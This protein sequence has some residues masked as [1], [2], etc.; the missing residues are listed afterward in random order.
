[1]N[2]KA[3]DIEN[4]WADYSEHYDGRTWK[5]YRRILAEFVLYA[6]EY[7]LLDVGCGY[8]FLLECARR[9]GIPATGLEGSVSAI[10]RCKKVHPLIDVLPWRGGEALP[11]EA[12]QIGGAVLNEFIDHIS[13][14]QNGFL[15]S[16]LRRV[17]KPKGL[18]LVKSP[19][20][21]NQLD[22]DTGHITFFSA[23]EFKE[24]VESFGFEVLEQ[25]YVYRPIF[26]SSG[27]SLLATRLIT[28]AYKPDKWAL[29]IDLIARKG[30]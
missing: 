3:P 7:P 5:D 23:E 25:P 2:F 11:F 16:E 9:F 13:V 12:N 22:Q 24:F 18:L 8:G 6:E 29:R 15:F 30:G 10:E 21:Y 14:E 20:K 17:L 28:K 26:G 1:M 4:W 19:S 27:T